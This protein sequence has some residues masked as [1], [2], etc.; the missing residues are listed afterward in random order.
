M[1]DEHL[2]GIRLYVVQKIVE[3][4]KDI[5]KTKVQ[6]ITYFLQEAVGVPLKYLFRM[7]YY[8]PYSD[9]LDNVLILAQ[10]VGYVEIKPDL[11]G[12]GYHVTPGPESE[13]RWADENDL[14]AE[15]VAAIDRATK[16]LGGLETVELELYATIHMIGRTGGGLSKDDTLG[17]VGKLKPKFSKQRIDNAYR[18]LEKAD[19]I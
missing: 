8:G 7:H 2:L 18:T 14:T 5:G 11:D 9:D 6:K 17:T 10:M 3:L 4:G 15:E 16:I 13:S 12:F 19:L 1:R